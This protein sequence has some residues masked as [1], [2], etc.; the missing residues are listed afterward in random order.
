MKTI[1]IKINIRNAQNWSTDWDDDGAKL[2]EIESLKHDVKMAIFEMGIDF[3]NIEV[4][5]NIN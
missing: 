5:A 3:T 1:E 4:E 2:A